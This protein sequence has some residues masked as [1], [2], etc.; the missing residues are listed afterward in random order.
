[1][2]GG[3][4]NHPT[5]LPTLQI[6]QIFNFFYCT[7][8]PVFYNYVKTYL[9][10]HCSSLYIFVLSTSMLRRVNKDNQLT[11]CLLSQKTCNDYWQTRCMWNVRGLSSS[12]RCGILIRYLPKCLY[13]H[14]FICGIMGARRNFSRG[15]QTFGGGGPKNL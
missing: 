1:M 8:S 12:T 11:L 14:I 9:V 4:L 13:R 6:F 15:G 5:I 3:W 7:M 2:G 10:R